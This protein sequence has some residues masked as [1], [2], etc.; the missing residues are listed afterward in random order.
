MF[1]T[2]VLPIDKYMR[3]LGIADM[4]REH[5]K[6]ISQGDLDNL[7]HYSAG[8]NEAARQTMIWQSEFYLTWT[9]FHEWTPFDS[10]CY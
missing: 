4:A 1:G 5:L 2:E 8:V 3:T 7:E 9:T 6:V 10:L